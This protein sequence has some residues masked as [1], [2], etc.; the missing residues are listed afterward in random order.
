MVGF[1]GAAMVETRMMK[2]GCKTRMKKDKYT[3]QGMSF[4]LSYLGSFSLQHLHT[5]QIPAFLA[6]FS[7]YWW[8]ARPMLWRIWRLM[9]LCASGSNR[10]NDSLFKELGRNP[11]NTL[12]DGMGIH[13][14]R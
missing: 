10:H 3:V 12:L 6:R 7:R 5:L 9:A 8:D 14:V 13:K 2:G 1:R 4:G 11:T